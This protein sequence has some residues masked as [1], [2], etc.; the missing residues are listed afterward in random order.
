MMPD[1]AILYVI[2]VGVNVHMGNCWLLL[3][4][5]LPQCNLACGET[6]LSCARDCVALCSCSLPS[7]L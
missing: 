2:D 7:A 6:V 5:H 3:A 1:F 4:A